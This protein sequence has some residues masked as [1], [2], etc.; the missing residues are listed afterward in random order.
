MES[1]VISFASLYQFIF[2]LV[3]LFKLKNH[4]IFAN[5]I[6]D[7]FCF[8]FI[9]ELLNKPVDSLAMNQG[10][11][12]RKTNELRNLIDRTIPFVDYGKGCQFEFHLNIYCINLYEFITSWTLTAS[13]RLTS[14]VSFTSATWIILIILIMLIIIDVYYYVK[15]NNVLLWLHHYH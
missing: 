5:F 10:D 13:G 7:L 12:M 14:A 4:Q 3:V 9:S 11:A 15:V 1:L 6:Y 8:F 2:A